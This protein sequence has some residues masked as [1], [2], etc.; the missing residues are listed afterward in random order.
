MKL[1]F[2]CSTNIVGGP[3]Q[4]AAN[5][6][7]YAASSNKHQFMFIVSPAVNT[8]LEKWAIRP[9]ILYMLDS[10]AQSKVARKKILSLEHEFKPDVVYTMAGPT[11]VK[12]KAP[13]VMGISNAYITHAN[14]FSLFLNRSKYYAC[15]FALKEFIKGWYARFS[16]D[17]FLFQTKTSCY[18]FCKRYRWNKNK[19]ALLQNALGE[20]FFTRS[21]DVKVSTGSVRKIFVPSTYFPHKNLEIIFEIC[22]LLDC[23]DKNEGFQFITTVQS[24]S[25]F[26]KRIKELGLQSMIH[27]IGPYMYNDS[28]RLYS[29]AD[30]VFIPSVLETFSTSYIE[31][32]AMAKPLIVADRPF[33]REICANYAHYYTPLSSIDAKKAIQMAVYSK[34]DLV[35]RNRIVSYYGSQKERFKKAISILENFHNNVN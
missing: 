31:A 20:S 9:S 6:I 24:D 2:N 13:H 23:T 34:V 33:S 16:A 26:S 25:I 10:P 28:H 18:G 14:L 12:F 27:N 21:S 17:Y 30:A 4:N 22:K 1:I 32:I 35:E 29:E 8:I 15:S 3:V 11:Y 7:K 5:F 19:T